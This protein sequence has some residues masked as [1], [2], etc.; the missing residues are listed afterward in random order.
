MSELSIV[1]RIAA[2]TP[3][4]AGTLLG[5]GDDAAVLARGGATVLS[6]D[7][8]VDGVHF[9]LGATTGADL[10]HKALA[11]NL[12]DLA[13]MGA[14]PAAA[15]VGIAAP[16]GLLDGL[17]DDLYSGMDALAEEFGATIV[18]GDLTSAR[19]LVLA[20]AVTGELP[21]DRAPITRSGA[22]PGHSIY[23]TGSLGAA[24]GGLSL[25]D[26]PGLAAQLADAAPLLAAYHRPWP[27][28]REGLR[29]A[30]AGV[31]AMMDLSDGL[32]LDVTRMAIA[33]DVRIELDLDRIPLAP[34]LAELSAIEGA[35]ARRRAASGGDDYELLVAADAAS[36][37][38]SGVEL[39]EIG[40]VL[41]GPAGVDMVSAGA[42]VTLDAAGW[43]HD[44]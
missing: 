39:T 16:P 32:A 4:R 19:E 31:A 18:G 12:S 7:L 38:A 10:G 1:E 36:A 35:D 44:V 9:R 5:V 14:R 20:V 43:T 11:V 17:V 34:G 27:R 2:L 21:G 24:A 22:R 25:L 40:R 29:L 13:A 30:E 8:L 15:L 33:S 28:V 3:T 37:G 41:D 42:P 23:V 26:E 6:Q